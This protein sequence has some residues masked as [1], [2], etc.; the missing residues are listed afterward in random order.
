MPQVKIEE[1]GNR[2][3]S[4][5]AL[6]TERMEETLEEWG[7]QRTLQVGRQCGGWAWPGCG[8]DCRYWLCCNARRLTGRAPIL[9]RVVAG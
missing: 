7:Q 2:V 4:Y 8:A 3:V 9:P 6:V 1:H 5:P